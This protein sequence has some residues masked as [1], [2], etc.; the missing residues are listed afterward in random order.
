MQNNKW[1]PYPVTASKCLQKKLNKT[2][3]TEKIYTG[4]TSKVRRKKSIYYND[5][6]SHV[7][8]QSAYRI[9]YLKYKAFRSITTNFQ[10]HQIT[11]RILK[12]NRA[13][14]YQVVEMGTNF[15]LL[16]RKIGYRT[17]SSDIRSVSTQ[18]LP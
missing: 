1:R 9:I 4:T 3:E 2:V 6:K 16:S 12:K 15:E 7:V 11:V 17:M 5:R 18:I 14:G 13:I 10:R 8:R